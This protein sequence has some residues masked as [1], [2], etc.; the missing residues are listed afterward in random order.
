MPP[1]RPS[2]ARS[3]APPTRAISP[4]RRGRPSNRCSF[5]LRIPPQRSGGDGRLPDLCKAIQAMFSGTKGCIGAP[6]RATRAQGASAGR[7]ALRLGCFLR[8][9]AAGPEVGPGLGRGR[10]PRECSLAGLPSSFSVGAGSIGSSVCHPLCR[11]TSDPDLRPWTR[12]SVHP[13]I[14]RPDLRRTSLFL[15]TPT[16]PCPSRRSG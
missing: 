7:S 3:L 1:F 5:Q 11:R 10:E 8:L 15:A 2:S 6:S 9:A 13:T 14:R 12:G 4:M 16:L